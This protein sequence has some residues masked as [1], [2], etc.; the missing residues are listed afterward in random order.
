MKKV[1]KK[2]FKFTTRR[3]NRLQNK[4][5]VALEKIN[6]GEC[7][8]FSLA[9]WYEEYSVYSAPA[10]IIG[11]IFRRSQSKKKFSTRSKKDGTGW[12]TMRIK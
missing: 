2:E 3:K 11:Q 9:D 4:I 6:V 1:S 12:I 5:I 10:T 8:E 7:L